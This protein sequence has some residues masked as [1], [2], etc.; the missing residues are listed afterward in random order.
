METNISFGLAFAAGVLSF[1]SPC[2]LPL[3]PGYISFLSGVSLEELKKGAGRK[4]SAVKAGTASIF[5]VIGFSIVFVALGA[6]ATFVGKLL[7]QYMSVFTKVAGAMIAILGLHLT[8][9]FNIG[10]LNYQKGLKIKG[11]TP[12]PFSALFIGMAFGFGW[13]PC[14]GPLLAGILALAATQETMLKGIAL[15]LAYSLGIGIPFVAT[16]F[17]V[18]I[19]MKFLEKY[20]KFI[21]WGEVIAGVFLVIIGTLMFLGNLQV[22]LK[23]VPPVF[24]K[25]A[26]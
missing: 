10:F 8:G 6:S 19:F 21:R 17:A 26:K 11:F 23:F 9:V 4:G 7:N 13:T 18:G 3:I 25:F 24:Y 20:R 2:V 14:V 15:L 5:F 1:L 12:G 22:L 16:G